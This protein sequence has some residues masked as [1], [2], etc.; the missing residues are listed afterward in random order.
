[1]IRPLLT[2]I[3]L[4][5]TPFAIYAAVLYFSRQGLWHSS[6]WSTTRLIGLAV[7]S[8]VLMLTSLFL[9]ARFSGAP[10]GSTYQ[11]AHIEDGKLVPGT[12]R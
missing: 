9:L 5:L 8:L 12:T 11:P 7:T 1:M 4:A 6:A 3:G 10:P 2:E